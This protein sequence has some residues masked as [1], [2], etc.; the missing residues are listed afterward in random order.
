L[1]HLKE[2]IAG[3]HEIELRFCREHRQVPDIHL[4]FINQKIR[5]ERVQKT[6]TLP[7]T[8]EQHYTTVDSVEKAFLPLLHLS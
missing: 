8:E 3:N 2:K 4:C 7:P 5:D 6:Q 1:L